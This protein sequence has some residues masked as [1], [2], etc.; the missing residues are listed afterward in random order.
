MKYSFYEAVISPFPCVK[1]DTIIFTHD[2]ILPTRN[3]NSQHLRWKIK[4]PINNLHFIF[5]FDEFSEGYNIEKC[6][7]EWD[8]LCFL[9]QF[10][11]TILSYLSEVSSVHDTDNPDRFKIFSNIWSLSLLYLFVIIY[12]LVQCECLHH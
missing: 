10:Q 1:Y 9:R 2:W 3:N 6:R 12:I 8:R 7:L 4:N 5:H 11:I